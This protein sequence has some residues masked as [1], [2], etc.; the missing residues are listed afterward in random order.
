[1]IKSHNIEPFNQ[2]LA[3]FVSACPGQ[4]TEYNLRG[5]K[6]GENEII[7]RILATRPRLVVAIG[8]LA[9]QATRE[10][11][12]DIPVVFVMVPNPHKYGLKGENIA[13][14]SLDIPLKTQFALYKSIAPSLK[15][16]GVIYDPEKTGAMVREA[17]GVAERLG[18]QLLAAPVSSQKAVPAA[19][20][21]LLGKID[22]LWM[23]PDDT[24]VTPESFKFLLLTAFENN[25]PF[26]T[27]SEIFVE[28]GAL[29]SLSPDY[30]E[31]GR[32]GCQLATEIENGRRSPAGGDIL[33]PA[34]VNLAVNLK[35]AGKIGLSLSPEILKSASKVYR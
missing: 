35:T 21:G 13:G 11:M 31:V 30:T 15:T 27:V 19:L 3:G 5:N 32:Q 23:V 9:A 1:M 29:A 17:G 25:L 34:K 2:A 24:V 18:L 4:I 20:R 6:R 14:I 8:A 7:Q 22:V 16:V 33:P 26:M 12:Q 10:R 28:A